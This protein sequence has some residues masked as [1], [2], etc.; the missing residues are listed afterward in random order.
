MPTIKT[1]DAAMRFMATAIVS[2][3]ETYHIFVRTFVPKDISM[4]RIMSQI[5]RLQSSTTHSWREYKPS[6]IAASSTS[7][8]VERFEAAMVRDKRIGV[9]VDR[10]G[11]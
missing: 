10:A 5:T 9:Q 2:I 3:L 7:I 11:R 1:L 4:S 6:S 8:A